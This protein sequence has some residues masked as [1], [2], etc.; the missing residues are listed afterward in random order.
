ML[1][2]SPPLSILYDDIIFA[3]LQAFSSPT[4]NM[5]DYLLVTE[6]RQ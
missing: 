1:N 4:G 3:K 5:H 2:E 6:I